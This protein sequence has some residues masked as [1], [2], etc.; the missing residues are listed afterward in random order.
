[1]NCCV[2]LMFNDA[3]ARD[4]LTITGG[5]RVTGAVPVTLLSNVLLARTVTVY[6]VVRLAGAVYSPLFDRFSRVT[7]CVA[8]F[9]TVAVNCC[10]CPT[11]SVGADALSHFRAVILFPEYPSHVEQFH[12]GHSRITSYS[13]LHHYQERQSICM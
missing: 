1:M 10:V 8:R 7:V 12:S 5:I 6:C 13:S 4:R 9:T 2:W 11:P 3:A